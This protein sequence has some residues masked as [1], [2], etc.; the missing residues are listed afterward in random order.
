MA[1]FEEVKA[2]NFANLYDINIHAEKVLIPSLNL[3]FDLNLVDAS[4]LAKKNY[5]AVDLIDDANRIAF[6]VTATPTL[7]KIKG[8]L[9]RFRENKLIKKYDTLYIYQYPVLRSLVK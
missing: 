1:R 4:A 8:T 3:V 9:D 5:P 7:D 2:Y 6:Q